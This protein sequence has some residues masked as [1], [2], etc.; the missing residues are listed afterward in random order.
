MSD[1]TL[2]GRAARRGGGGGGVVADPA[3][4]PWA[5]LRRAGILPGLDVSMGDAGPLLSRRGLGLDGG[6]SSGGWLSP[7]SPAGQDR[8]AVVRVDLDRVI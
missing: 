1:I 5:E 7:G 4:D 3:V 2:P 6:D 8:P